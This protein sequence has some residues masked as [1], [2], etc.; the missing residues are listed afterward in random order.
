M[1]TVFAYSINCFLSEHKLYR[2]SE[3]TEKKK[4]ENIIALFYLPKKIVF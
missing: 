3:A 1:H 2:F 4:M